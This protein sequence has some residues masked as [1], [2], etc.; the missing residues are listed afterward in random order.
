MA[1][2]PRAPIDGAHRSVQLLSRRLYRER[3]E[4][5]ILPF[6]DDGT[7]ALIRP[8]A[9]EWLLSS[10]I[11][12]RIDPVD[13]RGLPAAPAGDYPLTACCSSPTRSSRFVWRGGLTAIGYSADLT[14]LGK[15]IGGGFPSARSAVAPVMAVFDQPA[16]QVRECTRRH[17][18]RQSGHDGRGFE[19]MAMLPPAEFDR[20]ADWR[21]CPGRP[22][23]RARSARH[24][25]RRQGSLFKLTRIRGLSP[26]I[27]LALTAGTSSGRTLLPGHVRCGCHPHPDL[28]GCVSTVLSG[29]RRGHH[30]GGRRSFLRAN[31]TQ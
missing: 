28:A 22:V 9:A 29:G 20:L 19:S 15:I 3:P 30:A 21:P 18:Q 23:R 31:R 13:P 25:H 26:T 8:Y 12:C 6:N 10:S 24:W 5:L 17:L 16:L 27:A 4:H 1:S 11:H 14:T 2:T 7:E